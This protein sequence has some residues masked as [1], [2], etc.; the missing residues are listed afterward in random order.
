[1][2]AI[3]ISSLR[4]TYGD[5][6]AVD[7]LNLSVSKGE[8]FGFLGPNGAGKSTTIDLLLNY[9][10]PT[11][12]SLTVLGHDAV[13]ESKSVR[14]RIGVLSDGYALYDR[15]TG[16]EHIET[17][18]ELK[19]ADD[20]PDAVLRRVGVAQAADRPA[21]GYS[22]GMSQ[23]LALGMALV[24]DP[25]LLVFD[26]PSTGLD[27]DGVRTLRRIVR[28]EADHGA[29]V[30]FSSHDL[31]QVE[32][33][34]DRV[35]IL[36]RGQLVA[37]DTVDGLRERLGATARLWVDANPLPAPSPFGSIDGVGS[38]AA[39]DGRLVAECEDGTAKFS[40]LSAI[41]DSEAS[42]VDFETEAAS[43]EDL[44]TASIVGTA[45]NVPA[46]DAA[47]DADE[48]DSQEVSG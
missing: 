35:A 21:G 8:V 42:L 28:E 5:T 31:D 44:F 25:D 9:A 36:N 14:Q 41:H 39:E 16:R 30:F 40:L 32:A 17:A 13:S 1:M 43:L 4:K 23:R 46:E 11:A 26:E 38:V 2:D 7:D 37:V 19:D 48:S 34:C 18:I 3:S 24:G 12:G 10:Y 15:L 22:K 33:V 29:T 27:P 47:G 6:V 45:E 20:D